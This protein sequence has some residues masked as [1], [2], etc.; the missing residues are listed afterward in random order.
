MKVSPTSFPPSCRAS[1]TP[2]PWRAGSRKRRVA[3]DGADGAG[4]W[5]SRALPSALPMRLPTAG[6]G[7]AEP[8]ASEHSP[9]S[10]VTLPLSMHCQQQ[11]AREL[12]GDIGV[13]PQLALS[14]SGRWD[15]EMWGDRK[16]RRLAWQ[17]CPSRGWHSPLDCLWHAPL[18]VP[19]AATGL[20][21]SPTPVPAQHSLQPQGFDCKVRVHA[22][23]CRLAAAN[24]RATTNCPRAALTIT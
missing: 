2:E 6:A 22:A 7:A 13:V 8:A 21:P 23:C 20:M 4:A 3:A 1:W 17:P 12:L 14:A 16:S 5:R 19:A 18:Q 10:Q 11:G 15:V 9:A 24:D